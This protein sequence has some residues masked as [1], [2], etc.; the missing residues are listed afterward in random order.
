M[1]RILSVLSAVLVVAA[2]TVGFTGC[3]DS[4][5]KEKDKMGKDKMADDK[6]GKDKMA[7]DKM[8]GDKMADDKM[9]GDKMGKDKMEK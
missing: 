8:K 6:M 7:D 5:T 4:T 2:L 9:K 3:S 1:S